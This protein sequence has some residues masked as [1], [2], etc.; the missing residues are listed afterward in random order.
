MSEGQLQNYFEWLRQRGLPAEVAYRKSH[1]QHLPTAQAVEAATQAVSLVQKK[2]AFVLTAKQEQ[3]LSVAEAELMSK[4]IMALNLSA[5]EVELTDAEA[6]K[7][8]QEAMH[9]GEVVV[10]KVGVVFGQTLSDSLLGPQFDFASQ[11]GKILT[12]SNG[13]IFRTPILVTFHPHD[14]LKAPQ[15]KRLVWEDLQTFGRWYGEHVT[16]FFH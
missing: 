10:L 1:G 13:S 5:D 9:R 4:I 16:S 14:M 12:A 11:R 8:T 2:A 3:C 15:C 6:F 7:A